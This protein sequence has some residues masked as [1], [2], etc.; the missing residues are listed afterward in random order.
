MLPTAPDFPLDPTDKKID[1]LGSETLIRS[2]SDVQ[3]YIDAL[4]EK[5][6]ITEERVPGLQKFKSRLVLA[7]YEAVLGPK[8]RIPE[9]TVS[10]TFN[11]LMDEW[12]TP[13]WT[14]ITVTELHAFRMLM[15]R[16]LFPKSATRLP[17]GQI[18]H[19]SR[20]LEAL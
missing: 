5:F 12:N 6:R 13:Q 17:D 16:Y 18:A 20:P 1:E 9:S 11:K 4:L 15:S 14:R 19:D 10:D 8:K 7:E 2:E 3:V